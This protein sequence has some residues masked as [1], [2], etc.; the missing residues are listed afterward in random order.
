MTRPGRKSAVE[1]I[2]T[3]KNDKKDSKVI[4]FVQEWGENIN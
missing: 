4:D 2:K 1:G 3:Q